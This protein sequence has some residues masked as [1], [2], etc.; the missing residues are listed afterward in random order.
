MRGQ[1][2]VKEAN[3]HLCHQI[4]SP[5]P[6]PGGGPPAGLGVLK[7]DLDSQAKLVHSMLVS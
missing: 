7:V 2:E 5:R 6:G 3:Q 4:D 1:K